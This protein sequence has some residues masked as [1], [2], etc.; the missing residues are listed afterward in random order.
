MIPKNKLTFSEI[1]LK[2][3]D[4]QRD[5]KEIELNDFHKFIL[6]TIEHKKRISGSYL[7]KL[8]NVNSANIRQAILEIRRYIDPLKLGCFITANERGY[9]KS[10]FK[11]CCEDDLIMYFNKTQ[12]RFKETFNELVN[13]MKCLNKLA[14]GKNGLSGQ[15]K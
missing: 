11:K 7:G 3:Y 10:C 1:D 8:L 13:L 2:F 4:Q 15:Q 14:D 12:T 9:T 5:T 6:S